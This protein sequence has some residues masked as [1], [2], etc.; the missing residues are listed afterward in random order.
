MLSTGE[1]SPAT[2]T[3]VLAERWRHYQRERDRA[4]RDQLILAYSPLV[5]HVAG[6]IV[7]RMPA[8]VDVADLVSY[9]L[10]GLIE[11][12][13][14]FEP[15]LGVRF[16]TYAS[17]RIRGAIFDELRRLDWVPRA[18]RDEARDLD[19][20]SAALVTRLQRLPTDDELAAEV[21][22]DAAELDA[23]LLRVSVTHVSALDQPWG[24]AGPDG[25]EATL[26]ST[27]IDQGAADPA[28]RS[29]HR[30]LRRRIGEAVRQLPER[31]RLILALRYEEDLNL[32]EIG[33]IVGLSESRI[34][35][36]ATK[37]VIGLRTLLED[38]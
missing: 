24:A 3:I 25:A 28:Q 2:K 15:D 30:D 7:S 34:C 27:L 11:A 31:E 12:V 22:I 20:A 9:G 26:L 23:R 4:T 35:Q 6:K 32:S 1:R 21:G 13:E 17:T 8:H 19:Q 14:R 5:K 37:T 16:E 36:I 38:G 33:E 29:S 18:V 10:G